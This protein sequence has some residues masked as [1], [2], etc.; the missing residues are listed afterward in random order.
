MATAKNSSVPYGALIS[1]LAALL[2]GTVPVA[3]FIALSE[4]IG[5]AL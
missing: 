3:T 2:I 4:R 5:G 1:I